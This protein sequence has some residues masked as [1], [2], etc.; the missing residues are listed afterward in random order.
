LIPAVQESRLTPVLKALA[1]EGRLR[2]ARLLLDGAFHVSELCDVLAARQSTVSRNLKI[3]TDAGL[4]SARREGRLVFYAWRADEDAVRAQLRSLVL[5]HGPP[6]D[7]AERRRVAHVWEERRA[8][9]ADFFAKVDAA[10]PAAAWLGSPDCLPRLAAAVPV[11]ARVADVGT[12][13]GR[14]LPLLSGRA[15]QVIA[16]DASPSMLDEAR[17]AAG[18]AAVDL[19][20]GDMS[21]LP[22]HD[23]EVDTAVVN[24]ALHHVPE[25]R[26][27]LRELRRVLRPGGTLLVGDFL[28]HHEEWMRDRMADQWLGFAPDE[29]SDWLLDAGFEG[30][31]IEPI[32]SSRAGALSVFVAQATRR[33]E[34]VRS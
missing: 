19:R 29:L 21:H 6:P 1:D 26:A 17:R 28:P 2:L 3:L 9:S 31:R 22:L 33:E 25:P 15:A 18:G 7:D 23:G 20:L 14:M 12:G 8:R 10:D 5:R 30:V 24:M 34:P 11:G 27:A 32:H 13:S 16:V 4:L